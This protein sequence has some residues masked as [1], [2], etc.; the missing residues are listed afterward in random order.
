MLYGY[1]ITNFL[2]QMWY[3]HVKQ[4]TKTYIEG[5]SKLQIQK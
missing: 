2:F 1:F 3:L 5:Y 4:Y